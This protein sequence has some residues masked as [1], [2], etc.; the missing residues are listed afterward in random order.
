[1]TL[2]TALR[3]DTSRYRENTLPA[4]RAAIAA[5]ADALA[6]DLRT[7][8]DGHVVVVR[9]RSLEQDW[10]LDRAAG[11][12]E[13]ADLAVLGTDV[14]QRIPTF[15]EVLAE[16]GRGPAPRSLLCEVDSAATALAADAVVGEHGMSD[17]VCFTGSLGTLRDVRAKLPSA[18]TALP[19]QQ[20]DL[21]G[22]EIWEDLRPDAFNAD[23]RILTR[24][25]V[26]E[27]QRHGYSVTAWTVDD[28]PEMVRVAGMGVDSIITSN[29]AELVPLTRHAELATESAQQEIP[30]HPQG[31]GAGLH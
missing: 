14:E 29:I 31:Q 1:M 4:I 9:D 27:I 28:F 26:E 30:S 20:S 11:S 5:G 3:G 13:L 8:A 7:T 16:A 21:P 10:G 17:R 23:Y 12:A 18:G 15:M 19:W 6:V 22:P 24:E 25:L 2:A